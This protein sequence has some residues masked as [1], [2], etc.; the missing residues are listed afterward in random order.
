[1]HF[2]SFIATLIY[3]VISVNAQNQWNVTNGDI[4]SFQF[5]S[6]NHSVVQSTFAAPCTGAGISSGFMNITDPTGPTFPTWILAVIDASEPVWFF[7]SQVILTSTHCQAGMVFAINPTEA[8]SFTAFQQ[9]AIATNS[10]SPEGQNPS[11]SIILGTAGVQDNALS[12]ISDV[13]SS[14]ASPIE[15]STLEALTSTTSPTSSGAASAVAPTPASQHHIGAIIGGAIGALAIMATGVFVLF[16]MRRNLLHRRALEGLQE[17]AL[18]YLDL[19]EGEKRSNSTS[20]QHMLPQ[21]PMTLEEPDPFRDPFS[22][23]TTAP[24]EPDPSSLTD[25][26][27]IQT[28]ATF[29]SRDSCYSIGPKEKLD[30]SNLPGGNKVRADK[31]DKISRERTSGWI[32]APRAEGV[33][34]S[35]LEIPQGPSDTPLDSDLHI[36]QPVQAPGEELHRRTKLR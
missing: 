3:V 15:Q 9:A 14:T 5:V 10:T 17:G 32:T 11:G 1:M 23:T 31:I 22:L 2:W 19:A 6:K 30:P 34:E 28:T 35:S 12:V 13:P 4:V 33:E 27:S 16:R 18:K 36:G 25:A 7:C 26:Y 29:V 24:L 20:G 21:G 8:K